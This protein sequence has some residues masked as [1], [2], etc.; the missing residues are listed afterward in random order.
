M[1]ALGEAVKPVVHQVMATD[2]RHWVAGRGHRDAV[3][4]LYLLPAPAIKGHPCHVP[5]VG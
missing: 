3:R 4:V 5:S 1:E 2:G